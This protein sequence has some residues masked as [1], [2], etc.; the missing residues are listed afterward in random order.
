MSICYGHQLPRPDDLPLANL[1]VMGF[2]IH[3]KLT[4]FPL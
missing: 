2:A 3:R 1:I 4:M